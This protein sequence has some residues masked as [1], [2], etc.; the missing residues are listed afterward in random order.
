MESLTIDEILKVLKN[1]DTSLFFRKRPYFITGISTDTRTI[2]KKDL[3]IALAGKNFDG[4]DF[5]KDAF[6]KGAC[7]AIVEKGTLH[8]FEKKCGAS[9]FLIKVDDTLIALQDI[10]GYY[11]DKFNIT[12]IG[13]TGSNGKTTAKE[14]TEHCISMKY[15]TL[16]N[17]GNFNNEIG[18]PLTLFNLDSEIQVLVLEFATNNFGEIRRLCEISKPKIGVVLNIGLTHTE[19]LG[20]LEG[21]AKAKV[22]LIETLPANGFAI[23]NSDDENV[24]KMKEKAK[25]K[26]ITYGI[27]PGVAVGASN[28]DDLKDNGMRFNLNID[29]RSAKVSS[30]LVGRHNIYNTLAA[31]ACSYV[32][33]LSVDEI[34]E[35]L[36]T[37][38]LDLP[39]RWNVSIK[40]GIKIIDDSYN[41]NPDSMEVSIKTFLNLNGERK[42][43]IL[44]D[45]FELGKHSKEFHRRIGNVIGEASTIPSAEDRNEILLFTYGELAREIGISAGKKGVLRNN[46]IS[47]ILKEELV[48]C[49]KKV[50][51]KGDS[52]LIKGSHGMKMEEIVKEIS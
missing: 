7:G 30:K 47:T 32:L 15:K 24:Y 50:I 51:R 17:K 39:G 52:V 2:K 43:L 12:T 31:S 34:K 9:P 41:A 3:F 10:A 46:I 38:V 45:M 49:I 20:S 37:F 1:R 6:S 42:I 29:G 33:G 21:V 40:R 23:L 5:I 44:A 13:I 35:G 14:I 27:N 26:I 16:K 19:F 36:E 25:C 22:E 11:R 28:I 4:H 48:D 18:V 8:I